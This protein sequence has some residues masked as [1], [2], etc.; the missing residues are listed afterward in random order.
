MIG[1]IAPPKSSE[2]MD[3]CDYLNSLKMR[4]L[5]LAE[6]PPDYEDDDPDIRFFSIFDL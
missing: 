4:E 1:E 2:V 5:E 6:T 3:C